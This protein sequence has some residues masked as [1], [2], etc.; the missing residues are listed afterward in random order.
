MLYFISHTA[1]ACYA[2]EMYEI[3]LIIPREVLPIATILES[4]ILF[5]QKVI[6]FIIT[7]ICHTILEFY[8]MTR[9]ATLHITTRYYNG[10]QA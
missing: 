8:T 2:F 5:Q 3:L 10:N 9:P 7:L 6:S 4:V 1:T